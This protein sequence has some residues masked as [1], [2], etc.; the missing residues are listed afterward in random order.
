MLHGPQIQNLD[1]Y[2]MVDKCNVCTLEYSNTSHFVT[3]VPRL[4]YSINL[5][6][7]IIQ[8][9]KEKKDELKNQTNLLLILKLMILHLEQ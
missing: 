9:L 1:Q 2:G 4:E 3:L 6:D 7:D 5:L 8:I